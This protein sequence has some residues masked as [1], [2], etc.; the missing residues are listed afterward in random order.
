M[1]NSLVLSYV[2]RVSPLVKVT[3]FQVLIWYLIPHHHQRFIANVVKGFTENTEADGQVEP[4][5][6]VIE[7]HTLLRDLNLI[8]AQ[9]EE[10]RVAVLIPVWKPVVRRVFYSF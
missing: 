5:H 8:F 2:E 1:M 9:L 7:R 10:D 4:Q 3:A 6:L